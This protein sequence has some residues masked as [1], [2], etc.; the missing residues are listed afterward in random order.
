MDNIKLRFMLIVL[1]FIIASVEASSRIY[2]KKPYRKKIDDL[3]DDIN[4]K[5]KEEN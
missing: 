4:D 5:M 2:M 1:D 3:I